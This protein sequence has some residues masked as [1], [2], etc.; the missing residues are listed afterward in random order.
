M[1][2]LPL[3]LSVFLSHSVSLCFCLSHCLFF[4]FFPSSVF[5]F[6]SVSRFFFFS[7]PLSPFF[8]PS[9]HDS[10]LC[11]YLT[12]SFFFFCSL[13]FSRFSRPFSLSVCLSLRFRV[14]LGADS[15]PSIDIDDPISDHFF[16]EVWNKMAQS[17][18]SIYDTVSTRLPR[19]LDNDVSTV[20]GNYVNM[21]VVGGRRRL[22]DTIIQT[23]P[24]LLFF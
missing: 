8:P 24:L 4:L 17:N 5:L 22:S 15:D 7:D 11:F 21:L 10:V 16:A 6:L 13:F 23:E 14:L 2:C 3:C 12:E 1:S 19:S 9:F 18:A 20:E